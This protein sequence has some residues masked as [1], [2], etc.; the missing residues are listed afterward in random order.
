MQTYQIWIE[1]YRA[2]GEEGNAQFLG[3]FSGD[4][5][6]DACIKA[7]KALKWD[8]NTYYDYERNTFWGCRLYDN[9]VDARRYFG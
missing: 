1:G 5:F 4:D 8:I 3:A 6:Q 9:E 7:M 2:T